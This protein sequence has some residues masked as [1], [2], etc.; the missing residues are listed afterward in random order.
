MQLCTQPTRSTRILNAHVSLLEVDNSSDM[1]K[2]PC[3]NT[4]TARSKQ[5]ESRRRVT[6]RDLDDRRRSETGASQVF[7]N[8]RLRY[9]RLELL[10]RGQTWPAAWTALRFLDPIT[11]LS[12]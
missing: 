1:S 10:P 7:L 3:E 12:L 2:C 11:S 9:C 8:M 6:G 5:G 4:V